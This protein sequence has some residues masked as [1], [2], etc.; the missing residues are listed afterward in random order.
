MP[1]DEDKRP[2]RIVHRCKQYVPA[3]LQMTLLQMT[4]YGLGSQKVEMRYKGYALCLVII[5]GNA[6]KKHNR[7]V[8][9]SLSSMSFVHLNPVIVSEN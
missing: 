7:S 8:N 4:V 3:S 2:Q 6:L 1:N 9:F 5:K